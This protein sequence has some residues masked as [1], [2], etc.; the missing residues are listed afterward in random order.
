MHETS[1]VAELVAECERRAHGRPVTLVRVRHASS[2]EDDALRAIFAALTT[3]GP[4]AGSVLD[5]EEFDASITCGECGYTG[6]L[7]HDHVYGHVRV[8][9]SCEAISDD[10]LGPELELLAV[11]LAAT[12]PLPSSNLR[13]LS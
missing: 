3:D 1:L 7:D 9:P 10:A 8:C 4:L 2:I 6:M 12:D 11:E 13:R 5:A